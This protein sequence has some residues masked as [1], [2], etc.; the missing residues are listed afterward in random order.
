MTLKIAGLVAGEHRKYFDDFIVPQID[1]EQIQ[2]LGMVDEKTRNDLFR[3]A[4]ANLHLVSFAEPF[5]LTIVES[6]ACGT[7]VIAINKGSVPEII[8]EGKTGFIVNSLDEAVERIDEVSTIDRNDCRNRA[9]FFSIDNMVD[10]YI[11]V[12]DRIMELEA[13]R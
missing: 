12:Y 6:L 7:P 8:T 2:Y 1:G 9:E 10:G 13:Y 11:K 3:N 5:G 4:Y